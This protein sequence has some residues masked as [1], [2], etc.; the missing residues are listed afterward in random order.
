ME[1]PAEAPKSV[2]AGMDLAREFPCP[3]CGYDLRGAV[4]DAA[5][6]I[7]CPECGQAAPR[8]GLTASKIPWV[9]RQTR[10]RVRTYWATL[11]M[12][13]RHPGIL[14]SEMRAR[15]RR[16]DAEGFHRISVLLAAPI[17]AGLIAA[18]YI[19]REVPFVYDLPDSVQKAAWL[20]PV[21][22]L[23]NSWWAL[24][25]LVFAM[26]IALELGLAV[27]RWIGRIGLAGEIERLRAERFGMYMSGFA[28]PVTL[29]AGL[30]LLGLWAMSN[31]W[32]V[33][34]WIYPAKP[35]L[36]LAGTISAWCVVPMVV[37]L[38][39]LFVFQVG[40]R[41]LLCGTLVLMHSALFLPLLVCGAVFVCQWLAGYAA[42][43]I[44]SCFW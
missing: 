34:L 40:R 13:I 26:W 44:R 21:F 14:D 10:G 43:V 22:E 30:A 15:Q 38:P 4:A 29:L 42:I 28:L 6:M 23:A 3:K 16:R 8:R 5:G 31:L 11:W 12:L 25:P 17:G 2:R 20:D 37:V 33:N 35:Y 7:R 1:I 41:R 39:L 27:F 24:V 36:K 32:L 19:F 9:Y 18:S